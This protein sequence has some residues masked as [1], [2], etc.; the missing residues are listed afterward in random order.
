MHSH[1]SCDQLTE[2]CCCCSCTCACQQPALKPFRPITL[3]STIP[4][5]LD[6]SYICC[7]VAQ[8][9]ALRTS[10][11]LSKPPPS[12]LQHLP[13][14]AFCTDLVVTRPNNERCCVVPAAGACCE[15]SCSVCSHV[16]CWQPWP[17][18]NF[19]VMLCR[20]WRQRQSSP[21]RSSQFDWVLSVCVFDYSGYCFGVW[22][23]H[24]QSA[25]VQ[26]QNGA[27]WSPTKMVLSKSLVPPNP[28][29]H[30]SH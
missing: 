10:S 18:T 16:S 24:A 20:R 23:P 8:L 2:C 30:C 14:P 11:S 6:Q 5:F 22:A 12:A 7:E 19:R 26:P 21:A 4:L 15:C 28:P 3:G 17:N 29:T 9:C 1:T 27:S 25:S 13:P